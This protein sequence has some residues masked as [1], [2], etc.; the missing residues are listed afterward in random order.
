LDLW[1]KRRANVDRADRARALL[2][3]LPES[4]TKH[5]VTHGMPVVDKGVVKRA[6]PNEEINARIDSAPVRDVP[7][8]DLH[9]IQYSVKPG[10]V[11][12][13]ID[14]PDAVPTGLHD[15]NHGGIVDAPI[16]IKQGGKKLLW[17]GHHRTVAAKLMGDKTIKA[18]YVDFDARG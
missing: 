13:F 14:D 5:G 11:L 3:R 4:V 8:A 10:R 1:I 9:A 16:V 18:R 15:P 6:H 17:D 12:T 2:A 7:I